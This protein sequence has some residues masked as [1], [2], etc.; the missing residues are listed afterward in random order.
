MNEPLTVLETVTYVNRM[1]KAIDTD[2]DVQELSTKE[3]EEFKSLLEKI[4][5]KCLDIRHAIVEV[6]NDKKEICPS[7]KKSRKLDS[8]SRKDNK[9]IVCS[10]CGLNEAI[11]DYTNSIKK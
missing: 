2:F 11:S 1:L 6:D 9:T 10:D 4:T 8:L 7:C 5:A 3:L